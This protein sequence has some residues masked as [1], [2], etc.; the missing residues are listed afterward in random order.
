MPQPRKG[1]SGRKPAARKSPS[2]S[3]QSRA[4]SSRKPAA[5]KPAARK[6]AARKPA[7][8]K[9][10]ARKPSGR[11]AQGR[12]AASSAAARE[13]QLRRNLAAV[14]DL[15]ARG[16]VITGD[17]IQE[18]MDDAVKRGRMTRD[19]AEELVQGLVARGRK[20][21]ED[22]LAEIERLLNRGRGRVET[23]ASDT[24][25]RTRS[26]VESAVGAARKAP[27]TDRALREVDRARRVAGLGSSF[28]ITGYD[29]LTAAQ[30][31]ERIG[32]LSKPELRKVRDHERRNANRKSVLSAVEKKLG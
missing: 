11:Q 29:D 31:T 13:E 1:S 6:P 32:G 25:K 22:M 20:Q 26:R 8:R 16:V 14:R 12:Q 27:G 7:A 5:R 21:T 10:A 19:D 15:L 30:V 3:S 24:R 17:R 28:P 9:P 18:A 2:R 23:S 4:S